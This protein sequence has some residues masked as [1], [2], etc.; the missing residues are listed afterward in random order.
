MAAAAAAVVGGG[1]P[2]MAAV[3]D[4]ISVASC[5]YPGWIWKRNPSE[6]PQRHRWKVS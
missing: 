6:I 1:V 4:H 5:N 2:L 3:E